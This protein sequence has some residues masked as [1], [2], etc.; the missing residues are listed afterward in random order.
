MHPKDPQADSKQFINAKMKE[1]FNFLQRGTVKVVLKTE[2]PTE[3]NV[4]SSRIVLTIKDEDT[5]K[6]RCKAR[7]VVANKI[8][9]EPE[10]LVMSSRN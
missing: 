10:V 5:D 8:L 6:K 1:L 9:V 4:M 3:C 2:I 7:F